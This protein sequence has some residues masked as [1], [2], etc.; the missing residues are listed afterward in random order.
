MRRGHILHL[1]GSRER[2][3]SRLAR[4]AWRLGAQLQPRRDATQ[5]PWTIPKWPHKLRMCDHHPCRVRWPTQSRV[6][7]ASL[8]GFQRQGTATPNTCPNSNIRSSNQLKPLVVSATYTSGICP[9]TPVTLCPPPQHAPW[10]PH[11][12][13]WQ[14]APSPSART[15]PSL[16]RRPCSE[17]TR[18]RHRACALRRNGKRCRPAFS[19]WRYPRLREPQRRRGWGLPSSRP[20]AARRAFPGG[21]RPRLCATR[22]PRPC[23]CRWG[24]GGRRWSCAGISD[25]E[26]R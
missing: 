15:S 26:G 13:L 7:S 10:Q 23:P 17:L 11:T 8:A 25:V 20:G 18:Q 14:S 1:G 19:A 22:W 4:L 16:S 12:S 24:G 5:A 2:I 9:T 3:L 6:C 21:G